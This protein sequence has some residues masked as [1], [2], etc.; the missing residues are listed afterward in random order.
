MVFDG[1]LRMLTT[2]EYQFAAYADDLII[3]AS[4][5]TQ[6]D[7]ERHGQDICTTVNTWTRDHHL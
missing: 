1:L 3:L 6:R 2:R 7:L 4:A 5:D